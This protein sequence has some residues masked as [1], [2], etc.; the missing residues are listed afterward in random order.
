MEYLIVQ[1]T[2]GR[3]QVLLSNNG[4]ARV[5]LSKKNKNTCNALKIILKAGVPNPNKV[6]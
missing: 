6:K 1:L 4:P 3:H 5:I 2:K